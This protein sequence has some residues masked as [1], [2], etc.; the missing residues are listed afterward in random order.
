MIWLLVAC[1]GGESADSAKTEEAGALD[2]RAEIPE[3]AEGFYDLVGPEVEIAPYT[4]TMYCSYLANDTGED[5]IVPYVD[6]SQGE[7]GHHMTLLASDNPK[8]DGTVEDCTDVSDM[9]DLHVY[10][11]GDFELPEGAAVRI[12]AGKQF[13]LQS[14]Y[15]NTNERPILTRDVARFHLADASEVTQWAAPF[16]TAHLGI[17]IPAGESSEVTFDCEIPSDVTISMM[18]GHMHEWGT[19]FTA[20]FGA[21]EDAM[22]Q[23]INIDPWRPEYRDDPPI[24]LYIENPLPMAAGTIIRTHCEWFNDT[25]APII[26][27]GE[28]CDT[29]GYLVGTDQPLDCR[30]EQ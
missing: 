12:P 5:L 2:V 18:S 8:P 20:S 24:Q 30:V 7:Y 26:F 29:F 22:E 10:V 1:T 15:V 19:R 4:E 3:P 25:D 28:M 27:P 21:S 6:T 11:I 13:V 9:K 17:D 16:A 14:H 23:L